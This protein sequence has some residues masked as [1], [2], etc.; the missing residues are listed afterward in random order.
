LEDYP[1]LSLD[2]AFNELSAKAGLR[3]VGES[4]FLLVKYTGKS[5]G[6][7]IALLADK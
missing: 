5:E 7:L 6:E 4:G 2:N 3:R 1:N